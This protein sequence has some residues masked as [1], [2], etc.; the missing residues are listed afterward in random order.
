[1]V[2]CPLLFFMLFKVVFAWNGYHYP[3]QGNDMIATSETE[4]GFVSEVLWLTFFGLIIG[5]L[6]GFV[7]RFI[8]K[9]FKPHAG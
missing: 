6:C 8:F 1:M 9:P 3:M 5:V 2:A 4:A 7:I